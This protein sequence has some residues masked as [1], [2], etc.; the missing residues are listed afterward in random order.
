MKYC[1]SCKSELQVPGGGIEAEAAVAIVNS[2][3]AI[4]P[5][6]RKALTGSANDAYAST[7]FYASLLVAKEEEQAKKMHSLWLKLNKINRVYGDWINDSP[8]VLPNLPSAV[9]N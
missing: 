2:T 3:K 8:L 4:I 9:E 7:T 6:S 5:T 1:L